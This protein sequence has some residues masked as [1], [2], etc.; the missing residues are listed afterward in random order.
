LERCVAQGGKNRIIIRTNMSLFLKASRLIVN[1]SNCCYTVIYCRA[2][3]ELKR[4]ATSHSLLDHVNIVKLYA[5][6]Y[7]EC[8]YGVVLE[9]VPN[10]GLD[11]FLY[12]SK[13]RS[14]LLKTNM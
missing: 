11:E 3:I 10:G 13:V 12:K 2:E 14:I 1:P 4:E 8:H 5:M 9:Y 7:E 6:V